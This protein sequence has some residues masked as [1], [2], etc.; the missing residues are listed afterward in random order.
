MPAGGFVPTSQ[1][2]GAFLAL[3][4]DAWRKRLGYDAEL[5]SALTSIFLKTLL[6]FYKRRTGGKGGGKSGAVVSVQRTSSDLKL[7]PHLHA[8]FLDG[9]VRER[10][11]GD[12]GTPLR[13]AR[14]FANP[15]A[16][17]SD[18]AEKVSL[19]SKRS[20]RSRPRNPHRGAGRRGYE[21]N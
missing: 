1:E 9:G 11:A 15:R 6:A 20:K 7:N 8:V 4:Q 19:D 14:S 13:A 18:V 10:F 5:L 3:H 12:G 2:E 17:G 16:G 21:S